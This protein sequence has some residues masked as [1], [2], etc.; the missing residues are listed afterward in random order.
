MKIQYFLILFVAFNSTCI[1]THENIYAPLQGQPLNHTSASGVKDP[2]EWPCFH[3]PNRS[4]KS[5]ETGL[6]NAWPDSGP[7][8]LWTI[9]GLGEGYSSISIAD[10]L[11]YTSGTYDNQTYVFAFDLNGKPV[12]K[13]PNGSAW[14]IEVSWARGYD[15]SRSTPTYDNGYVYHLSE[16]GRLTAYNAR[17]GDPVWSRNIREDFMAGMPDYGFTESV[18]VDGNKLFV[19]PGGRKGFQVCLN[20]RTGETIWT[21]NDISGTNS[22]V[23]SILHDFGGYRQL[24]GASSSCYYGIDTETGKLLWKADFENPYEVNCTDAV[25]VNE[26][27]LMSSGRGGGSMLVK[28]ISSG[29][30]IRTEKVWE[31]DLMD[32]YHG[33]II[34]H[35]GYFYGSGDISRGWF[36]IDMLSG[37][38]AWKSS[39]RMGSL[40]FAEGMLYL[41]DEK[42]SMYII[43]ATPEKF[44]KTGEFDVP[45][46]GTGP[47]WAHP[48]VCGGRLYIRHS[49]K[50]FAYNIKSKI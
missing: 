12:W 47:Y 6:M 10:G 41:Y 4:N 44:E 37:K 35:D 36:A 46:G 40:T 13:K 20:K 26:Y 11:I 42:G 8:L 38:Q 17:T 32:N 3:G 25:I 31:T 43:K 28:L 18:L 48:V 14:K 22:Y 5:M 33:G 7:E 15:G 23:S 34:F 1:D 16:A 39:G 19:R 2:L 9:S 50:L 45:D 49:D 27:V 29:S 30:E 24:I 21:N